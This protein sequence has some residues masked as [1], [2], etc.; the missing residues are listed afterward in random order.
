MINCADMLRRM[1]DRVETSDFCSSLYHRKK[2]LSQKQ[3][4]EEKWRIIFDLIV[5]NSSG[6][7][8]ISLFVF[9]FSFC[10]TRFPQEFWFNFNPNRS[11]AYSLFLSRLLWTKFQ[12]FE[13][14]ELLWW[15]RILWFPNHSNWILMMRWQKVRFVCVPALSR[16]T[17]LHLEPIYHFETFPVTLTIGDGIAYQLRWHQLLNQLLLRSD[18]LA[19]NGTINSVYQLFINYDFQ[20]SHS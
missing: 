13:W 7:R 14:V 5:W 16:S 10:A 1:C 2:Q 8:N 11:A 12:M 3:K 15:G 20:R 4:R 9:L 18:A 6:L 19:S 17:K